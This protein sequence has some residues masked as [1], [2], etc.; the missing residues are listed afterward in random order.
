MFQQYVISCLL[1]E[2]ENYYTLTCISSVVGYTDE[3]EF[4]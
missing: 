2:V 1:L 4:R 3:N